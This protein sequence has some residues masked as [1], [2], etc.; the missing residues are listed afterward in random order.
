MDEGRFGDGFRRLLDRRAVSHERADDPRPRR[1]HPSQSRPEPR[2]IVSLSKSAVTITVIRKHNGG[3][4]STVS[5]CARLEGGSGPGTGEGLAVRRTVTIRGYGAERNL[6]QVQSRRRSTRPYERS[7]FKPDRAA[8][9]AVVLGVSVGV[10]KRN[11]VGV[12]CA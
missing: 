2:W 3:R 4:A 6:V 1:C 5:F 8:L 9:W 7:G 11:G 12:G 10:R